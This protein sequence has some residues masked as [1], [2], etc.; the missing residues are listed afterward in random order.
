M[1]KNKLIAFCFLSIGTLNAFSDATLADCTAANG[2]LGDAN[3]PIR[4]FCLTQGNDISAGKSHFAIAFAIEYYNA[5]KCTAMSSVL[6]G[7]CKNAA[8][9]IANGI[10]LAFHLNPNT[11]AKIRSAAVPGSK[12]GCPCANL[13]Q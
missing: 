11:L 7:N 5:L 4:D 6:D 1:L 10:A 9:T 3:A 8:N 2:K 12:P 13:N